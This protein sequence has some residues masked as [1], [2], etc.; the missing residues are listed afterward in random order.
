M[1]ST[2]GKAGLMKRRVGLPA[3]ITLGVALL[4]RGAAV[5]GAPLCVSELDLF[6]DVAKQG[7]KAKVPMLVL[8]CDARDPPGIPNTFTMAPFTVF[9][10]EWQGKEC[11]GAS[12]SAPTLW[13]GGGAGR[14]CKT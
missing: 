12:R 4:L 3:G 7:K 6:A 10:R 13:V 8:R 9:R 11:R 1:G 5:S 2:C 14:G